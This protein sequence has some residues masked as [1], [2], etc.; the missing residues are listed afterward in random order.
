M[1]IQ[2]DPPIKK[3]QPEAAP[4]APSPRWFK[5]ALLVLICYAIG[6]V[7]VERSLKRPGKPIQDRFI[8]KGRP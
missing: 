1:I 5:F 8:S 3:P 7:T 4:G 6:Y 2:F